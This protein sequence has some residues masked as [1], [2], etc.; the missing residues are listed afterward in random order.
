MTASP[1]EPA[2]KAELAVAGRQDA[3][4]VIGLGRATGELVEQVEAAPDGRGEALA[5][6]ESR[7]VPLLH[8]T[9]AQVKRTPA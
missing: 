3:D 7:Q 5:E 6:R 1:L 9:L 2:G 4:R 8:G